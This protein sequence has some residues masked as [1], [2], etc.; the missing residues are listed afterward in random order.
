MLFLGSRRSTRGRGACTL[1]SSL[2]TTAAPSVGNVS[3]G[4]VFV[5]VPPGNSGGITFDNFSF[6]GTVGTKYSKNGGAFATVADGST[7]TFANGDTI[8]MR[9]T[10]MTAGE[11][12]TCTL[13]D[14]TRLAN[15]GTY[16]IT[17]S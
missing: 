5:T 15:I 16:T 2:T 10:G 12:W 14:N 8:E 17:A 6:S 11:S 3:T 7:I 1:S 9:G 13:Q 4:A